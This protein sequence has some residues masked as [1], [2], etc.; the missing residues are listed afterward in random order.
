MLIDQ[1]APW[2]NSSPDGPSGQELLVA[3][4]RSQKSVTN[5]GCCEARFLCEPLNALNREESVGNSE[6][7][8]PTL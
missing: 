7:L 3:T 5:V 2:E 1:C 6:K 4:M 8:R